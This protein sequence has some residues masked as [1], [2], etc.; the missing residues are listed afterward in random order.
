MGSSPLTLAA[1]KT[2]EIAGTRWTHLGRQTCVLQGANLVD[3]P[4][5]VEAVACLAL[6]RACPVIVSWM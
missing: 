3:E 1:P 4:L 2:M 5:G 6:L